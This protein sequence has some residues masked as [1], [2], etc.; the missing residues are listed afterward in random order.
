MADT[1]NLKDEY[2]EEL[3]QKLDILYYKCLLLEAQNKALHEENKMLIDYITKIGVKVKTEL[4]TSY[5]YQN[6]CETRFKRV[7][8]DR[9]SF[10]VQDPNVER[11]EEFLSMIKNGEALPPFKFNSYHK[12]FMNDFSNFSD[13]DMIEYKYQREVGVK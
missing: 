13:M 11:T 9:A 7:D 3:C 6:A 4:C 2:F 8:L 1:Q 5:N 12:H 10:Y